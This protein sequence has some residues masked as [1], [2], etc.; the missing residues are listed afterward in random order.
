MHKSVRDAFI[1]FTVPLEGSVNHLYL[2]IKGLCTTAIGVLVDPVE[3]ALQLP[4]K[5]HDG[6]LATHDEIRADWH[7]LK[8]R[9]ELRKKHYKYAATVTSIRL[10]DS[11]VRA[12]VLRKL[13]TFEA[14]LKRTFTA[15][16]TFPADA[17]LGV[18]SI[19]WAVGP[20][21][22]KT[23]TNFTKY[24]LAGNWT[25]AGVSCAIRYDNN[26]GVRPRNDANVLCFA[27]AATVVE[28]GMERD[29]LHWPNMV[30]IKEGQ[31]MIPTNPPGPSAASV[32][33]QV[34]AGIADELRANLTPGNDDE[35]DPAA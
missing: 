12:V 26:P 21:F 20:A 29:V 6:S 10:D 2:D 15:W 18:L 33:A 3:L 22:T 9:Q 31:P 25:G 14:H 16:D 5:R 19:A 35:P 1:P 4:W 17:Q 28:L 24:A 32:E 34:S 7:R 11:D 30:S 8:S 23:F 13:D 27:N